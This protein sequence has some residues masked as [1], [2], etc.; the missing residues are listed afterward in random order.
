[1]TRPLRSSARVPRLPGRLFT[2]IHLSAIDTTYH[3]RKG[4]TVK[5]IETVAKSASTPKI[6]LF[7]VLRALSRVKGICASK[8]S[9]GSGAPSHVRIAVAFLLTTVAA[10]AF[11]SAPALAVAPET[12][13]LTVESKVPSPSSPST[14]AVFHGVL[15]PSA[16]TGE[17][18]EYAFLYKAGQSCEGGSEAPIP[19]GMS[20]GFQNEPVATKSPVTGLTANTEYTVCLV[21]EDLDGTAIS[22]AVHFTTATPPEKPVTEASSGETAITAI[23]HGTV[24]PHSTTKAGW[25][26]AYSNP[27]GSSCTEGPTT[28]QEQ[29]PELVASTK[30][31][32]T[33]S[34]LQPH[35]K[36][37]FCLIATN[38]AGEEVA[39]VEATFATSLA[40][41]TVVSE[42]VSE[43]RS[44]SAKLEAV[45][46][47]NNQ[48]T[49]YAFEY[50]TNEALA[51]AKTIVGLGHIEG[52]GE[53]PVGVETGEQLAPATRYYYRVS[54]KNEKGEEGKGGVQSFKTP[55]GGAPEAPEL[56][57]EAIAPQVGLSST[58]AVLHGI[59][60]PKALE[61]VEA[62][63]YQFVYRPWT[64][65]EDKCNGSEEQRLPVAPGAYAG[66]PDESVAETVTALKGDT[67]YAVCLVATNS[68]ATPLSTASAAVSFK[69]AQTSFLKP[70]ISGES[71]S[72]PVRAHEANLSGAVDPNN[73]TTT[74]C[75][76]EYGETS[77]TEHEA[78]CEQGNALG[79]G[80][81]GVS[82]TVKGLTEGKTYK[83]RITATNA[84]GEGTG[85]GTTFTTAIK[86]ETPVNEEVRPTGDSATVTGVLN[87]KYVGE[88]GHY[89]V[90]YNQSA[91]ECM[92]NKEESEK[93][94]GQKVAP[95]SP[96]IANGATPEPVSLTVGKLLPSTEYTFCLRAT[97][98]A[99]ETAVGAP[100]TV[101]T[102]IVGETFATNVAA[103]EATVDAEI[104]PAG[105][106]T[107]YHTE[108]GTSSVEESSAPEAH[109]PASS[110]PTQAQQTLSGLKAS[111]TY[112]Y[113]V[114]ANNGHGPVVGE[115]HTFTTP[116]TPGS[117]PPATCPNAQLR[118]E[119]PYG[120]R[121]PQCRAYEMV[122]P[123]ESNGQN[124]VAVDE[125]HI[126]AAVSGE[127]VTYATIGAFADPAGSPFTD[128]ILS[129]RGADGWSTQAITAP[130]EAYAGLNNEFAGYTGMF[131]T[132][133]LSEGL[134]RTFAALTPE[135]PHGLMGLYRADFA[136]RS[137]QFIS[138]LPAA[139]EPYGELYSGNGYTFQTG[140]SMDLS[141]IV[142]GVYI[143]A[144]PVGPIREWVN[145]VVVPVG[146]SNSGEAWT[147]S[148]VGNSNG[149]AYRS[150]VWHA[151][152]EDGSHV[153]FGYSGGLYVRVNAERP[154]S[155]VE[156]VGAS[157][158]C[159]E[160]ADA[161]TVKL[162][163]GA[164]RYLGANGQDTRIFY[165][166]N[167]DLYEASLPVG[168]VSP[169]VTGL[170]KGAGV[171]GVVE[172]SEDG[173]YVYFAATGA[174]KGPHGEP[175]RNG[176]GQEPQAG[177]PNLYLSH[178]G[179]T[180]FIA[181]LST[182]DG[183][184]WQGGPGV[185]NA[186]ISP[187]GAR[188]AFAS[189]ASLTGYDNQGAEPGECG[190][191]HAK[192]GEIHL[193]EAGSGSQ[194]SRLV[195]AS[196][197]PT[198]ARPTGYS[199]L[200][201]DE[202]GDET[203]YQPRDLLEDGTLFFN[204]RDA[205]V[206]HASDGLVNVYEYENGHI[207]AI[208]NVAGGY[209]SVFMDASASGRDVFFA[210]ADD[211]VP[212]DTTDSVTVYDAR[213]GGGFPAPAPV[214]GCD[215]GD[216][217]KPPE[218]PQPAAFGAPAS[219]TFSGPGNVAPAPAANA[220]KTT[221]K[222]TIRCAKGFKKNNRGKCVKTR[223]RTSKK[224]KKA[225]RSSYDRRAGR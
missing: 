127:A 119:Q 77:V 6:G 24:D 1:M 16:A 59:L 67:E 153:I 102:T 186:A 176:E 90:L 2:Q 82:K 145:G 155:A 205:L 46:D 122:S 115:E 151:V 131:F 49:T 171:Q 87:A 196:C 65:S 121:L 194:P 51:G 152:S 71:V 75:R 163:P 138:H 10:L 113:R 189:V 223:T 64:K 32:A 191:E 190:G 91:D 120:L 123:V 125:R 43:T 159:T 17:P 81:Q 101:T 5:P 225:K 175:L 154:Q 182:N 187:S 201:L 19:A 20:L 204:S 111:S 135:A 198:G 96:N 224:A 38:S 124:A 143:G 97:N 45:L 23:L 218:T 212:Q 13:T 180:A 140:A 134:V 117:E 107:S 137:Y 172:I 72:L 76:F 14:E 192:C 15:N 85:T 209:E 219:T 160:P 142:F 94:I 188:L 144:H 34:G 62:G 181:T 222:K 184:D 148:A 116:A 150:Y 42:S 60:S 164:A 185:N 173:S 52:F 166:E 7:A 56:T 22:K 157:E 74:Q 210:T 141:H 57:V 73:E 208:S 197:D 207:Y 109:I 39:G 170:T 93:G 167:E 104:G 200:W 177:K 108:Y 211:L 33:V 66:S 126:R 168:Q 103:N 146:V 36:Y 35:E 88:A 83:F 26:F 162:S 161:C 216:S 221:T 21:D 118:A 220:P 92:V 149:E 47:P 110:M 105:A 12:P 70:T 29:E 100:V 54:A 53:R 178:E 18:G 68:E 147:S 133:E 129:R 169:Q 195:C 41:P 50:A 28:P 213:V 11:A 136:D 37:A 44:K 95:E 112:H 3:H 79:G 27:G 106:E 193:F 130:D 89:E 55:P 114:V 61:P 48:E 40:A 8:V 179:V 139:E 202:E 203:D 25:H 58:E 31:Q 132:P 84:T 86:P 214:S 30:V 128:Q 99:G 69:T 199:S 80:E 217:C 183:S 215:N 165:T 63:T 4:T 9:R 156:G 78:E 174:L 206:P 158:R 98:S